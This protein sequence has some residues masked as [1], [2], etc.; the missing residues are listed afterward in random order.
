MKFQHLITTNIYIIGLY[1]T[2]INI[3]NNQD[4]IKIN[5]M[6]EKFNYNN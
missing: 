2:K 5:M 4:I 1:K 3:I 6:I